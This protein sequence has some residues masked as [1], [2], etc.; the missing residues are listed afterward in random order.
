MEKDARLSVAIALMLA[1]IFA[2]SVLL[3]RPV[4][5][6]ELMACQL[7]PINSGGW[8]YR[9]KIGGRPGK[10]FYLGER[11]KPR[12]E[13]YWAEAPAIPPMSIPPPSQFEQRWRGAED[14]W[15][16]KE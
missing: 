6:G 16:H 15:E 11:M 12:S 3:M 7:E 9:T 10:C 5:G 14:G 4:K 2:I 8:H 1:T 13:L